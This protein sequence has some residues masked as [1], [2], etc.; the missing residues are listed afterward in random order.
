MKKLFIFIVIVTI[1]IVINFLFSFR[2]PFVQG[3]L[4]NW[5]SFFG[6]YSGALVGGIVAYFISR[7]QWENHKR[8]E[9][10]NRKIN[11]LFG[12][13]RIKCE[14]EKMLKSIVIVEDSRKPFLSKKGGQLSD[15]DYDFFTHNLTKLDYDNWV[16][17]NFDD[18]DLLEK[19][20]N[21]KDFYIEFCEALSLDIV[22]LKIDIADLKIHID[23]LK[24]KNG[25]IDREIFQL[26]KE[27]HN[28]ELRYDEWEHLKTVAW[29]SFRL[30][31]MKDKISNTINIIEEKIRYIS[32]L[33][34]MRNK[35][36]KNF[37]G[38]KMAR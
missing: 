27:L 26:E 21:I 19:L 17:M 5:F 7:Y 14:L 29:D 10:E 3:S 12:L 1:P 33:K 16:N 2:L 32:H 37:F 38:R 24:L 22:S 25:T 6:S 31:K 30:G 4:D 20:L 36:E 35:R 9:E 28:L 34:K 23:F 13:I 18:A 11:E 8:N 15:Q